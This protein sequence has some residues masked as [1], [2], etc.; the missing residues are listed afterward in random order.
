VQH[1]HRRH[2]LLGYVDALVM[3]RFTPDSSASTYSQRPMAS[4]M[5]CRASFR[6]SPWE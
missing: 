2:P 4:R 5:F 6:V 3:V 1:Q